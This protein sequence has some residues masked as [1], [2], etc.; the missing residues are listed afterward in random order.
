M[1]AIRPSLNEL[2]DDRKRTVGKETDKLYVRH[3]ILNVVV[4]R[5]SPPRKRAKLIIKRLRTVRIKINKNDTFGGIEFGRIRFITRISFLRRECI[6]I[7]WRVHEFRRNRHDNS[8]ERIIRH[9]YN[10]DGT[11]VHYRDDEREKP[12]S[13]NNVD[14]FKEKREYLN[15]YEI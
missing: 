4:D 7:R 11:R 13:I 5:F 9:T 14:F 1:C 15:F 12:A 8:D 3:V 6:C 10:D 2:N